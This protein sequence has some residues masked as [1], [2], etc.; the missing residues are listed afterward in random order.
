MFKITRLTY[1]RLL[2]TK[3]RVFLTD[4]VLKCSKFHSRTVCHSIRL[5]VSQ[6]PKSLAALRPKSPPRPY[7]CIYELSIVRVFR[8]CATTSPYSLCQQHR[9]RSAWQWGKFF[10]SCIKLD[11]VP[12]IQCN[13]LRSCNGFIRCSL[14]E[15][16]PS[17]IPLRLVTCRPSKFIHLMLWRLYTLSEYL[18]LPHYP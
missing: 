14:W 4:N 9:K 16:N 8:N 7:M 1:K 6:N 11:H 12:H 15:P 2:I 13:R 17:I 18:W 10:N 5:I 3:F